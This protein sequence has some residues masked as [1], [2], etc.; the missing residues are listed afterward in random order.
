MQSPL[1]QASRLSSLTS[2]VKSLPTV[3]L[4]RQRHISLTKPLLDRKLLV[5][6]AKKEANSAVQ[7]KST[8]GTGL[9]DLLGPI[10]LSLGKSDDKQV[11][12][13]SLDFS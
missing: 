12:V 1:H 13:A 7:D 6:Q 9:G 3:E 10:G 8:K 11:T 2:G 4:V 5:A